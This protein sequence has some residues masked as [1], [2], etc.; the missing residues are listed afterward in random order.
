MSPK[1][2][3]AGEPLISDDQVS[4]Y[5]ASCSLCPRLCRVDRRSAVSS[6]EGGPGFCGEN[7]EVRAAVAVLHGGEEPPVSG[8]LSPD[9]APGG[10]SNGGAGGAG[11]V[12]FSGCSVG[13]PYCQN[14][15]I[16]QEGAGRTVGIEELARIY[17]MLQRAGAVSL[18]LVTPTH[19]TP[20]VVKA[21]HS[22]RAGLDGV[23]LELPVVWNSSA[24]EFPSTLALADPEVSIYLPDLKTLDGEL[25]ARLY[26]APDYPG[27]AER[28]LLYMMEQKPLRWTEGK[29]ESLRSGV[30][31]RHMVLPGM[32]ES[33]RGVL[34]WFSRHGRGRAL[35]SLLFQYTPAYKKI[36]ERPLIEREYRQVLDWLDEYGIEDGFL[37]EFGT[38][39]RWLPDFDRSRPFPDPDAWVLWPEPLDQPEN[40]LS[41]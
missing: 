2:N 33:T 13:C 32:L 22:A 28:A 14:Y 18:D 5:Y 21:L 26:R 3:P 20:S 10:E 41:R 15:Q 36:P 9:A 24:Y 19:F 4:Q 6:G 17:L 39:Q 31:I 35:L 29:A 8:G 16:S 1:A 27:R 38:E 12:F 34:E 40:P 37:Q 30:I 7:Q 23:C 11:A 25:S